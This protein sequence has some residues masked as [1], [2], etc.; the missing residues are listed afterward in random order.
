MRRHE[1][2]VTKLPKWAQVEIR[3]LE[4]DLEAAYE[5]ISTGPE[6]SRIIANP[7]SAA[8]TP[9]GT[10]TLIQFSLGEHWGEKIEVYLEG[11]AVVLRGGDGLTIQPWAG[12]VIKLRSTRL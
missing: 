2:D 8:P 1:G 6:D 12:N 9:L 11:D 5:K 10:T 4:R 7:N 3:R